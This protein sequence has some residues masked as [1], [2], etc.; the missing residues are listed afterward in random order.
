LLLQLQAQYYGQ[1][2]KRN[3]Y[4]MR[5]IGSIFICVKNEQAPHDLFMQTIFESASLTTM[6]EQEQ[7]QPQAHQ[8]QTQPLSMPPLNRTKKVSRTKTKRQSRKLDRAKMDDMWSA[9]KPKQEISIHGDCIH[10]CAECGTSIESDES[11]I[12][13]CTNPACSQ[14][15]EQVLDSTPE[16]RFYGADDMQSG[17]DPSRCGPAIN[18]LMKDAAF[19]CKV[20]NIR[21]CNK[22]MFRAGRYIEWLTPHKQKMLYSDL[23]HIGLICQNANLPKIIVDTASMYYKKFMDYEHSFRGKNKN[24]LIAG[25]IH[26]SCRVNDC[27]R[28]IKEIA[29]IAGESFASATNGCKLA[30][31]ILNN[32]KD[33]DNEPLTTT[34]S[35]VSPEDFIE[36]YC[37]HLHFQPDLTKLCIFIAHKI[38]AAQSMPENTPTSIAVGIVY[39]VAHLFELDISKTQIHNVS[40]ISEMTINKCFKRIQ[41][42][43]ATLV[44]SVLLKHYGVNL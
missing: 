15:C 34:F 14:I 37:S 5:L 35:N 12:L 43:G 3:G 22:E 18:P 26:L 13:V 6:Q 11:G 4:N 32:M 25:A 2:V 1:N 40:G 44:P 9:A 10:D 28:S 23:Q 29:V 17:E 38:N 39:F 36:R 24:G 21:R 30:Q 7:A 16:W 27:P 8:Q 20:L 19:G 41:S 33:D 31:N 42:M